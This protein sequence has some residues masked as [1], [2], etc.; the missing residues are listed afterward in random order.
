MTRIGAAMWTVVL[1]MALGATSPGVLAQAATDV[2][3]AQCVGTTDIA[4]QAITNGRLRDN[5]V[6]TNKIVDGAVTARKLGAGA[7][8]NSRIGLGAV[9]EGRLADGAVTNRKIRLGA[10]RE[11]RLAT[12]AVSTAKLQDGAVTI[13][14]VE[15]GI[16]DVVAGFGNDNPPAT[17]SFTLECPTGKFLGE[18]WLFAGN[19]APRGTLPAHGQLISIRDNDI[20]FSL[21]G[22]TYGGDGRISFG[23]PDMRGLEPAGVNYVICMA[24]TY[25]SRN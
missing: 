9:R 19:F 24:G 18:V 21:L 23:L 2:Q 11:G 17:T 7:V 14:K 22:T 3:C 12:G 1:T 16:A 13:A 20:L 10:V 6:T 4:L 8:T 15:A 5:A 25:P